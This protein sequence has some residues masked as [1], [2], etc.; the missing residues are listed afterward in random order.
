MLCS[1]RSL[2]LPSRQCLNFELFVSTRTEIQHSFVSWEY[3]M[4]PRAMMPLRMFKRRTQIG[5]CLEAFFLFLG[6]LMATYYL[7]LWYQATKGVSATQSG[8]CVEVR[9]ASLLNRVQVSTSC[10]TCCPSSWGLASLVVS[11]LWGSFSGFSWRCLLTQRLCFTAYRAVLA[12][13]VLQ[14]VD[15]QRRR[16]PPLQCQRQHSQRAPDRW[17]IFVQTSAAYSEPSTGYQILY[18][19][20]IGGAMQNTIIAIQ[21]EFADNEEMIPQATSLVSADACLICNTHP[22]VSC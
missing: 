19:I 1:R 18:G 4:G 11:Y 12:I 10:L 2:F 7:P 22:D 17:I 3:R 5:C 14:P 21:A 16:W 9:C 13:P 20:G 8:A 6:L 15:P